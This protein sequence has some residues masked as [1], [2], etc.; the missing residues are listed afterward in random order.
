MKR[1]N[2][3]TA[4]ILAVTVS[5]VVL[6][7]ILPVQAKKAMSAMDFINDCK[8]IIREVKLVDA[9]TMFESGEWAFLDVRTAKE[10]KRGNIPD[11]TH[12]QRGLLEFKIEKKIPDKFAKIVVYCK[13]GS[14]ST[15]AVCTLTK[16]GYTSV[17]SMVGGWK[18]WVNEGYPVN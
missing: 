9:R 8:Q 1:K 3:F 5:M 7:F 10:H 15:L 12:L 16:M 14:R 11:S 18:G 4:L 2:W 13:S 6:A 17:V